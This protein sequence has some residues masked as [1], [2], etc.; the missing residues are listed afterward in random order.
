MPLT[1]NPM[2]IACK[3]TMLE[4]NRPLQLGFHDEC[5]EQLLSKAISSQLAKNSVKDVCTKR[6]EGLS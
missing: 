3:P 1:V 6:V 4:E 2:A 5:E